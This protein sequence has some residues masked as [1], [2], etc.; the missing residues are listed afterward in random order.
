MTPLK[1]DFGLLPWSRWNLHS[2]GILHSILVVLPFWHFGTTYQTHLQGQK[3]NPRRKQVTLWFVVYVK[4]DVGGDWFS[5]H[6]TNRLPHI[7]LHKPQTKVWLAFFLGILTLKG[8]TARL[9]QNV[10]NELQLYDAY[11][12]RAQ[13]SLFS[14]G[15]PAKCIAC[16]NCINI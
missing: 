6:V 13:I 15:F 11:P 8:E 2:P 1:R 16:T 14:R 9:P 3:K 5:G 12:R 4:K 7:S 10:G